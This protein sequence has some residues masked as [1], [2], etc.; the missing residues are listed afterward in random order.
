MSV[1]ELF[2]WLMLV[3]VAVT[4]GLWIMVKIAKWTAVQDPGD[5]DE[6]RDGY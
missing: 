3:V 4:V 6:H 5:E 1:L 2:A